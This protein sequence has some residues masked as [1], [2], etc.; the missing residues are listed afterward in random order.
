MAEKV[1]KVKKGGNQ[2]T[3][4]EQLLHMKTYEEY[5]KHRN[6]LKGL[7]PDKEVIAHLSMLFGKTSDTKEELFLYPPNGSFEMSEEEK[8]EADMALQNLISRREKAIQ[9]NKKIPPA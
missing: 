2:M 4:K 3:A 8:K 1:A 6:E 7:K 9:K 5:E